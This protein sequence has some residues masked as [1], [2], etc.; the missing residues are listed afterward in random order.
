MSLFLQLP[1]LLSQSL[2]LMF[3]RFAILNMCACVLYV[4]VCVGVP[5]AFVRILGGCVLI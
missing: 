4:G 2:F 5:Q 1:C 3:A